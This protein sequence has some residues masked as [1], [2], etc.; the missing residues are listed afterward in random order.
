MDDLPGIVRSMETGLGLD[1]LKER[2]RIEVVSHVSGKRNR[3]KFQREAIRGNPVKRFYITNRLQRE[4]DARIFRERA[5]NEQGVL[6]FDAEFL[7]LNFVFCTYAVAEQKAAHVVR[8]RILGGEEGIAELLLEVAVD[9]EIGPPRVDQYTAG[10][11]VEKK[12]YV[13]ALAGDLHPLIALA[14]P[15]PLPNQRAV[16]VTGPGRD[17]SEHSVRPG[18]KAAKLNHPQR[19]AAN[20]GEWRVQDQSATEEQLESVD[21]EANT[22]AES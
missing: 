14:L 5:Q 15:L 4:F 19:S 2:F 6:G 13:H 20:L 11:V 21:E 17:R 10:I 22:S 18:G 7:D 8:N 3:T 9:I 1:G 16:V 12:G